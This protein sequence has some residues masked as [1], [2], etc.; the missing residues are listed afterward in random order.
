M[1]ARRALASVLDSLALLTVLPVGQ[2]PLVTPAGITALAFPLAGGIIGG[3]IWGWDWLV[4]Q[5]LPD[6]P[7]SAL[8]VVAWAIITGGLHLDGLADS[9]DG[10]LTTGERTRRLEA[11][12]DPRIGAFGAAAVTLILLLKWAA[13]VEMD[14]RLRTGA[15]LLGPCL[16]RGAVLPVMALF[17]LARQAGLGA[18]VAHRLELLPALAAGAAVSA[19]PLAIFSPMG[20]V[21]AGGAI[22]ASGGIALLALR[23]LGG[24]TGD[25]LGACVEMAETTVLLLCATSVE[26]GWLA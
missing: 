3:L 24:V 25:V 1:T 5:A 10:L 19:V 9:V 26:R 2:R 14:G 4:G 21:L 20:P 22:V 15:L 16:A 13:L 12:A 6:I 17:P 8:T 11:M 18:S 7:R 23:R